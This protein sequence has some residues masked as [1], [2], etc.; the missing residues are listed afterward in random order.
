MNKLIAATALLIATSA[1][2]GA[3][4]PHI[5]DRCDNQHQKMVSFT[6]C[7]LDGVNRDQPDWRIKDE[8]A[9]Q[10]ESILADMY[11]LEKKVENFE[12]SDG[13]AK[14]RA[15]DMVYGAARAKK[16]ARTYGYAPQPSNNDAQ[17][18]AIIAL[19]QQQIEAEKSRA[20]L[21]AGL[22]L[23][24]IGQPRYA[25]VYVNPFPPAQ[26]QQII[27]QQPVRPYRFIDSSPYR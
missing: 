15:I 10:F 17:L 1:N 13:A 9:R 22:R 7:V 2:A 14:R 25:P 8:D 27:I 12:I 19:Q 3:N 23:M 20:M 5:L 11:R 24:E 26:P 18:Q 4:L 6:Q 16:E 21:E